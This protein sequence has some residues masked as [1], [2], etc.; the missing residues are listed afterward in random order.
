MTK[1]CDVYEVTTTLDVESFT[2]ANRL[3]TAIVATTGSVN[4]CEWDVD[5]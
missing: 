2:S 4:T 3:A 5:L 1:G